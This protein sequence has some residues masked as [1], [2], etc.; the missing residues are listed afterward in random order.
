MLRLLV[1]SK[2]NSVKK[3]IISSEDDTLQ[4]VSEALQSVKGLCDCTDTKDD[5]AYNF[6]ITTYSQLK[7]MSKKKQKIA[8]SRISTIMLELES[9]SD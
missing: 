6:C 9:E 2:T 4:I 5:I 3:K 7:S 1:L 8:R